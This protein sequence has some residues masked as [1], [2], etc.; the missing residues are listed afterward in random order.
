MTNGRRLNDWLRA[1]LNLTE[2]QESPDIFHLWCGVSA[3][4]TTLERNVWLDRGYYTLYPNLYIVLVSGSAVARK[5][6]AIGVASHLY[7]EA[8]PEGTMVSQKITPEALIGV[9]H[10][11]FAKRK[12]SAGYI[13]ADELSVFL[14]DG[15]R[16]SS[17]IQLLTKLYD[18]ADFDYHTLIRGKE[19]CAN[20]CTNFLAGTAPEW[21]KTSLP[22]HAIGGG[23]TGRIVFV[24]HIGS[25]RRIPFPY[26][27]EEARKVR[28]NLLE[29]LRL[30]R[31]MKGEFTLSGDAKEWFEDWYVDVY[32]PDKVEASLKPY[33]ARKPDTLLK[34]AMVVSAS[35]RQ[36]RLVEEEDIAVA[37]DMLGENEKFLPQ[38]MQSMQTTQVGQDSMTVL[39]IVKKRG[40]VSHADLLR[41]VSYFANSKMLGEILE[42][43]TQS[44]VIKEEIR[45]GRRF[46]KV[47]NGRG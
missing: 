13:I 31:D 42:G 35:R 12:V 9:L 37:A 46:Y 7:R 3:I 32:E 29:D 43:L 21:L 18:G 45:E 17:L 23:F 38:M 14:G 25:G 10:E 15:A 39:N 8:N 16:D 40:V 36:T 41:M 24:H 6:T 4:A 5:S 27:S 30:I 44:G 34:V 26:V 1:Y 19:M 20:P 2:G 47:K 28:T 22:S 33:F 11:G